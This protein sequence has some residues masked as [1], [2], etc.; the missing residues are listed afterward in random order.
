MGWHII[1]AGS[2]GD[3]GRRQQ[4]RVIGWTAEICPRGPRVSQVKGTH[5]MN[6]GRS[7]VRHYLC[8][9]DFEFMMSCIKSCAP[10]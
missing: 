3:P 8:E 7:T 5:N 6:G 10:F 9:L 1:H 2:I 4:R